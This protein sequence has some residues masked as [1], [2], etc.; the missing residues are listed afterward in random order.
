MFIIVNRNY[1]V[2]LLFIRDAEYQLEKFFEVQKVSSIFPPGFRYLTSDYDY[3]Y[4]WRKLSS[5]L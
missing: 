5:T 2:K 4:N 3:F 1:F